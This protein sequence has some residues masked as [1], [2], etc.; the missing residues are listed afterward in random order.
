M[1]PGEIGVATFD[2]I[3]VGVDGSDC[4]VEALRWAI[5]EGRLRDATVEALHAWQIPAVGLPGVSPPYPENEFLAYETW[6]LE[7]AITAVGG[8]DGSVERR[9]V[10]GHAANELVEASRRA[11]LVVVGSHGH[12]GLAGTLLG[13]VSQRVVMHAD[14]PVVVIRRAA[15]SRG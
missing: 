6:V 2:R 13:S 4:S 3:V 12:G 14:C 8:I 7:D 1:E 11:D 9:V 5:E 10:K 15:L